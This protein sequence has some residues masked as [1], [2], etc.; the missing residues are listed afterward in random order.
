[1]LSRIRL[2]QNLAL[3]L[4][5]MLGLWSCGE[6]AAQKAPPPKVKVV[7]VKPQE[8]KITADFVGQT[9]GYFDIGIRARVEG[10]LEGLHFDE[11]STVKKGQLLYSIDPD[12]F[13]AKVV[14]Q[15][16]NLAR[17]KTALAK[18]Q[19][20]Y[21]RV[22]PLAESNA[23]SKSDLD[24]AIAQLDAAKAEVEA[25]K[26]AL[27]YSNIELSYTKIYSPISGIIGI[28]EAKVGDFVGREPNTVVL[29]AVSRTDTILVRFAITETQYLN[30]SRFERML[31]SL[32]QE[33]RP[34]DHLELILADGTIHN[35]P[36]IFDFA[37]RNVDSNTGTLLMQ[38]S[39]PNPERLV[40]PGQFARV[41]VLIA[42]VP[43]GIMVPQRCL[44]ETQGFFDV[45]VVDSENKTEQRRV[46]VGPEQ[47]NMR[48]IR[49][50]LKP[51]EKIVYEGLQ[52]SRSGIS[53][54]P[55]TVE[56]EFI[57]RND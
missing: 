15:E 43:D 32:E 19:A 35:Y 16:S 29:N 10:F 12:P 13:Q 3:F 30:L 23:V 48:I 46:E 49:S 5:L 21:S 41:R 50:G 14:Q 42:K 4:V 28:T 6:K 27:R 51:G 45:V 44:K 1:M 53:V 8:I 9:Y 34:R 39:F 11:G 36:G 52:R 57:P 20:D 56:V 25:E 47:G 22:K 33:D 40:R 54:E 18:A 24:A 17:S 31:D 7:E 38:A 55:E 2:Y 37:N 26:A